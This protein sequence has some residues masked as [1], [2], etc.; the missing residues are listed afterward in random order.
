MKMNNYFFKG[1][2]QIEI[3]LYKDSNLYPRL[4]CIFQACSEICLYNRENR[5][6][7]QVGRPYENRMIFK[8]YWQFFKRFADLKIPENH[9]ILSCGV[10]PDIFQIILSSWSL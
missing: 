10:S 9:M 5:Q 1:L 8:I 2:C 6:I 7:F 4:S 3:K